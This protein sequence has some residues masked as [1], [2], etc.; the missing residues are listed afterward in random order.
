[1]DLIPGSAPHWHLVLNHLPSV[2]TLV[3]VCLLAGARYTASRDL[4]RASLLLFVVLALM[5]IPAFITGGAAGSAIQGA[6]DVSEAAVSAH[7]D[8]ALLALATLL[9][10]G[11]LAWFLLWRDR[12]RPGLE[13]WGPLAV[14]GAGTISL[15]LMMWTARLG[16]DINHPEVRAAEPAAIGLS[17][18]VLDG[19]FGQ[20]WAWPA[21][22]I[23][24]FLGMALLFGAILL[25]AVRVLGFARTVPYAALHWL[26]PLGV[27][28]FA[29]NVVTG[30]TFFVVDSARYSAMTRGFYPKMALIVAGGVAAMYLTIFERPWELKAGDDAPWSAKAAAL[31]TV[32]IWSGVIFY[33]RLLPFLDAE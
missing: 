27:I 32:L 24:H 15:L 17:A 31:A 14:L 8:A 16:G 21:M 9:A 19:V 1:M 3:A 28:G 26:L 20:V 7:Q 18:A 29:L 30:L 13:G 5:G 2:G 23:V 25:A 12:R 10:T 4:T 6:P 33:G 11:W 22:E